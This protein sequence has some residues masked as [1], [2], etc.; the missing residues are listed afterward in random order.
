MKNDIY[1]SIVAILLLFMMNVIRGAINDSLGYR[2]GLSDVSGS[3]IMIAIVVS[4]YL[5]T[6]RIK[7]KLRKSLRLPILRVIFWLIIAYPLLVTSTGHY[8]TADFINASIPLLCF[9]ANTIALEVSNYSWVSDSQ[10]HLWGVYILG[11]SI[12][13]FAVLELSAQITKRLEQC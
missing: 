13:L 12:Y 10:F 5:L 4:F 6:A 2:Y 8:Q 11:V 3:L 1:T 7:M 9:L